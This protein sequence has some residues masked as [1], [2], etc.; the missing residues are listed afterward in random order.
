M[1]DSFPGDSDGKESACNA[2]DAGLIP[3]LGTPKMIGSDT[4]EKY[5]FP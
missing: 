4:T 1:L 5:V 2:E 3:E